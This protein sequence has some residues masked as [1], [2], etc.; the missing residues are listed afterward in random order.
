VCARSRCL[1][2]L[3]LLLYG[4]AHRSNSFRLSYGAHCADTAPLYPLLFIPFL[5]CCCLLVAFSVVDDRARG[6]IFCVV[7]L[8]ITTRDH[9]QHARAAVRPCCC[10]FLSCLCVLLLLLS[11]FDNSTHTHTHI[12]T[13]TSFVVVLLCFT[14]RDV[15]HK[16][17]KRQNIIASTINSSPHVAPIASSSCGRLVRFHL[18]QLESLKIL[19]ECV[20]ERERERIFL[21]LCENVKMVCVRHTFCRWS[22]YFS[23]TLPARQQCVKRNANKL[24]LLHY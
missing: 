14:T 5:C 9:R 15:Q 11:V 7:L 19:G 22:H 23:F 13:H 8:C 20:C 1:L 3:L 18:R 4:S 16:G 10:S 21:M 17:Y 6:S 12:H 24:A 2:L